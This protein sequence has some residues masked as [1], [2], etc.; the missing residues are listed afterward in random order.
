M[1]LL[2]QSIAIISASLLAIVGLWGIVFYYNLIAEI[3]QGIDE[4]LDNYRK[5]IIFQA[6]KDTVLLKQVNFNEGFYAIQEITKEEGI[7]IKDKYVDTLISIPKG[8]GYYESESF[9][10][11]TTAF[12]DDG[13]FYKLRVISSMVEKD[14]LINHTFRNLLL[15][16]LLLI[17]CIVVINNIVLRRVWQPFYRLLRQLKSYRLGQT[18]KFPLVRTNT[19]EFIN[20]QN[21]VQT[22]LQSSNASYE[23]QKEFISN[24]AH[25][26]QTPLA[27]ILNKLE[28]FVEK[29]AHKEEVISDIGGTIVIV[30]R[31]VRLN[32]SLLLLS[33]IESKQFLDRK[34]VSVNEV[35][36]NSIDE[37][38]DLAEH[39]GLL[40]SYKEEVNL[41]V[42]TDPALAE[43]LINNLLRNAVFHTKSGL[44][45]VCITDHQMIVQNPGAQP[46]NKDVLFNRFQ[47]QGGK[48][49]G[50]GLG[51]SIV[52]A[53]CDLYGFD[54]SYRFESQK[55]HFCVTFR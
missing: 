5:Q 18:K 9:R 47:R 49:E 50:T 23:Q 21:A 4:S 54:I 10:M 32:K 2:N 33:K 53:I 30:E 25:E 22:L 43:I 41:I 38:R 24:A 16:Y 26:L 35:L 27:I 13:Y 39:K 14:A 29:N 36:Q 44:V 1:K 40:F 19:T 52:K 55:H 31:L 6:H 11:L 45:E 17:I 37:L 28:L 12:E 34:E 15:L 8:T 42:N 46:L 20:L 7:E 3:K 48:T 51:L